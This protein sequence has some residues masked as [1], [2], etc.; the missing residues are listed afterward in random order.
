MLHGAAKKQNK[1]TNKSLSPRTVCSYHREI[2]W[3]IL[4]KS[5]I[6][7]KE[8]NELKILTLLVLDSKL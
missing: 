1:Q 5:W 2:N 3:R 7:K 8:M 4:K 6:I